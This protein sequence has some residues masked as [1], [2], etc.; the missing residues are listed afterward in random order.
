M[1]GYHV[2]T[3]Q[4]LQ[5]SFQEGV[6]VTKRIL[7]LPHVLRIV[8]AHSYRESEITGAV[9]N[10]AMGSRRS[11]LVRLE[12]IARRLRRSPRIVLSKDAPA[13]SIRTPYFRLQPFGIFF[14]GR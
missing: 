8:A 4:D 14:G 6:A 1:G 9:T 7:A 13:P 12:H 3:V 11:L 2:S 10:L 5:T